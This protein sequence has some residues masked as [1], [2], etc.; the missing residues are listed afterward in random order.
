M[1]EESDGAEDRDDESIKSKS[2]H[3]RENSNDQIHRRVNANYHLQILELV[4]TYNV[5]MFQTKKKQRGLKLR[6]KQNT[7]TCLGTNETRICHVT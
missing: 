5:V 1:M 4:T 6:K 3:Q 2:D 7:C